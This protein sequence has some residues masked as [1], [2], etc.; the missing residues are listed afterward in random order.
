MIKLHY[1]IQTS[2]SSV[3]GSWNE[4]RTSCIFRNK[5]CLIRI[6]SVSSS[7]P[8]NRLQTA[9]QIFFFSFNLHQDGNGGP[10]RAWR[11]EDNSQEEMEERVRAEMKWGKEKGKLMGGRRHKHDGRSRSISNEN[12][13]S[14]K[15]LWSLWREEEEEEEKKTGR[16]NKDTKKGV[17]RMSCGE[18]CCKSWEPE[19]RRWSPITSCSVLN[20][21]QEHRR[22]RKGRGE[23]TR[24]T[25][26]G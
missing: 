8:G 26:E 5:C 19:E 10:V 2:F 22:W 20:F 16:Y 17:V 13:I 25:E 21:R 15:A 12:P 11:G 24:D 7:S 14:K 3:C 6:F 23:E 9:E 4:V 1:L 18:T